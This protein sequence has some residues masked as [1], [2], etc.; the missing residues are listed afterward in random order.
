[1][2]KSVAEISTSGVAHRVGSSSKQV[3][4]FLIP[5]AFSLIPESI[6]LYGIFHGQSA[7]AAQSASTYLL[8]L[9]YGLAL[10][11]FLIFYRIGRWFDFRGQYARLAV[12][13]VAGI[14]AGTL[15]QFLS[16]EM[17]STTSGVV[18]GFM[19]GS[20][21]LGN[22]VSLLAGAFI[23]FAFPFAGLAM[24]F[25]REDYLRAAMWPS[26]STGERRLFSPLTF[27]TGF[28]ISAAAYISYGLM[29]V[30]GSRVAMS[31]DQFAYLRSILVT[32]PPYDGYA[33]SFFFPLL[34]FIAFYFLGKRM[35]TRGEGVVA[36]SIS[37]FS[38]GAV[39]FLVGQPLE[40]YI[41]AAAAPAGHPFPPFQLG[42]SFIPAAVISGLFVLAVG[43]AAATLG[44]VRNMENQMNRDRR[45]AIILIAAV[46]FLLALSVVI[47]ILPGS[48]T[49]VTVI[50]TASSTTVAA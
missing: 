11:L 46:L 12:L 8:W 32:F 30:L 38:A 35:D 40:Y 2:L 49:S 33:Y 18:K 43:F 23:Y 3:L 4:V 36:L 42:F 31:S 1:M 14:L 39:S 5:F 24:A 47:A 50:T 19:I 29:D 13:T 17:V 10:A 48:S 21:G 15:P 41:R 22:T 25:L 7:A 28:G 44:F 37:A 16:I 45:V 20:V 27:V 34:F 6:V 26:P 9:R